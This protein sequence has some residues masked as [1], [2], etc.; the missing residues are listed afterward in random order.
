[1]HVTD[2][3]DILATL[4]AAVFTLHR[5][6][7][8]EPSNV[9]GKAL[10]GARTAATLAGL[11]ELT[12]R[13]GT[14]ADPCP[15]H[16][17]LS[18]GREVDAERFCAR[19]SDGSGIE[20][21]ISTRV[22]RDLSEHPETVIAVVTEDRSGR[23]AAGE[24]DRARLAAIVASSNDAI[25]SKTLDGR[26]TSWNSSAE[27]I[28]GYAASEMLGQSILLLVPP[29]L[30]DEE[31]DI[32]GRLRR[33]ELV[34]QFDTVRLAKDGRRV[35]VSLSV[36]PL[37][38]SSG[39]VIGASKIARDVTRRKRAEVLQAQLFDELS[40]RVNNTLATLQSITALSLSGDV[41]PKSFA[42]GFTLRLRA[43][44]I[45]QDLLMR[46][47]MQGA[48]LRELVQT[49]VVR[50]QVRVSGAEVAID[51]RLAAPL[52]LALNELSM[53]TRS[54]SALRVDWQIHD[55]ATL[56]LDWIETGGDCTETTGQPGL[57]MAV[58]ERVL[59]GVD[60]SMRVDRRTDA[61]EIH[62]T[63]PL[64]RDGLRPE[65]PDAT[66][67]PRGPG[68]VRGGRRVLIVED[69]ALIAMDMEAQL[70]A[71]GWDVIGPAGTIDEALALIDATS[72]DVALV[73]A[74]VRGR[75]VGEIA[76]ALQA[77]GIPF[78]FAT[79]YGRSA[80]PNGFRDSPLLSKPF[81]P[82]ALTAAAT[83]ML[84]L[85]RDAA[86]VSPAAHS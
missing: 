33:G 38:D 70:T 41:D 61:V 12:R 57:A 79:G 31:A 34:E 46:G 7:L 53:N 21:L 58:V 14:P 27:R 29:Q 2:P 74:N 62:L 49:V 10:A 75:P 22:L 84:E 36:S 48:G 19:R 81:A 64:P 18:E 76:L 85:T 82:D 3:D 28:F 13:D 5:G 26:I 11:L 78:T 40:H 8:P 30:H 51:H 83:A 37:R 25:V 9:A 24:I 44:G 6:G 71:A 45:A 59:L 69:E 73:D 15:M 77:R 86:T 60:G 39:K 4:P 80:L 54:Q 50:P 16:L 17:G 47:L 1:M 43:L 68:E 66:P 35:D 63:L 67:T 56:E 52:A 20:V 32:L 42:A 65:A 72:F 23:A 55:D